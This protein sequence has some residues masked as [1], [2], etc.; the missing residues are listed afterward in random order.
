MSDCTGEKYL[1]FFMTLIFE[2]SIFE[3]YNGGTYAYYYVSYHNRPFLYL[4]GDARELPVGRFVYR[5]N[6]SLNIP[7]DSSGMARRNRSDC[8]HARL[9]KKFKCLSL[10]RE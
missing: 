10:H 6:R 8:L 5:G 3:I 2:F 1:D 7:C 4:Q 9:L